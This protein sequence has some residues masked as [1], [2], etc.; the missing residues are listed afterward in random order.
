MHKNIFKMSFVF[1]LWSIVLCL[2]L[3]AA[4]L[5][6]AYKDYLNND[7]EEALQKAKSLTQNDEVLYF[8]GLV[9]TKIGNYPQAREY[10]ILLTSNYPRSK[11]YEQ[12]VLKMADTYFLEGDSS[13]ARPFYESIEK[14]LTASN[15]LPL[16]YLRLSQIAAKEGRW[17]DKKRYINLLKEKYPL[18]NELLLADTLKKQ[19]DFF[20]IQVGAFS[21]S[22]N[23]INL[24]NDLDEKYDVYILED[25]NENYVLYKVRVGKFKDRKEAERTWGRLVKQGYPARIFP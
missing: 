16:A 8:L 1:G 11:F 24:K 21:N 12:G 13:K 17:E 3:Y 2:S 5:D 10:L 18:S 6:E 22:K 23:A 4:S 20:T 15:Y 19:E 7:Y 25:K 14:K 9:Y